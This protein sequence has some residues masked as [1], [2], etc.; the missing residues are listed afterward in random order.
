MPTEVLR[1]VVA[2]TPVTSARLARPSLD[3]IFIEQVARNRGAEAADAI[4][5]ELDHA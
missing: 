1:E 3:E 2:F 4:R 5:M